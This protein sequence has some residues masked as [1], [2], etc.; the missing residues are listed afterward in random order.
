[1]SELNIVNP[2]FKPK[3]KQALSYFADIFYAP[4]VFHPA[5]T[6]SIWLNY[7]QMEVIIEFQS[8]SGITFKHSTINQGKAGQTEPN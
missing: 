1:M 3:V 7:I 4:V 5:H 2:S 6:L 8:K